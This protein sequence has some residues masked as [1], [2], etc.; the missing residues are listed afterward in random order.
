MVH[1]ASERHIQGSHWDVTM[2]CVWWAVATE[3]GL[4]P[5]W[6]GLH[7]AKATLIPGLTPAPQ[8]MR[9]K[10]ENTVSLCLMGALAQAVSMSRAEVSA[11]T[12][13]TAKPA[14]YPFSALL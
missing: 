12:T 4:L 7:R 3:S 1:K 2:L 5:A 13:V 14:F 10:L 11:Q 9:G 6:T 8:L